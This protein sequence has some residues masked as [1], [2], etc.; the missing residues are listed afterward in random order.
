N[1]HAPILFPVVG[2]LLDN[3]YP[4][5]GQTY[6]LPQHGFARDGAFG[7][8]RA[9]DTTISYE[10]TDSDETRANYP[11]AFALQVDYTLREN[12]VRVAYTVSNSGS[13]TMYFSIG[14]HPGFSCPLL[15]GEA[16]NDYFIEFEKRETCARWY[17][18]ENGHI[19]RSEGDYL[20]DTQVIPYT[21]DRFSEDALIFK[22]LESNRVSIKS[23][24]NDHAVTMDFTGW[25]YL[26]IW[27]KP[28][29][30]PFICLEPW[31]GLSDNVDHDGDLTKK[32]G[33][34]ALE[35]GL[36]FCCEYGLIFT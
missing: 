15:E 21:L 5:E 3:T 27:S 23:V 36:N 7:V 8:K 16:F 9:S 17:V 28:G 6:T 30:V 29:G 19:H 1:R 34:M 33:I 2:R 13:S 11:F 10:L 24:K 35:P 18:N 32:E 4:C 20:K 22:D 12:Q 25:S 14:G 31:Y 26:G